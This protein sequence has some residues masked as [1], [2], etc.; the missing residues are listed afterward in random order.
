MNLKFV[1]GVYEMLTYLTSYLCKPKHGIIERMKKASKGVYG[2]DIKGRIIQ[3]MKKAS[4]VVYG[5][6]IRGKVLSI[7]NIFF[8]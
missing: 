6:D 3:H 1:T 8:D 7:C 4:K 5:K 2:K